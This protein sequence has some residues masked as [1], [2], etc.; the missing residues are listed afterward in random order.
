MRQFAKWIAFSRI[1]PIDSNARMDEALA[2]LILVVLTQLGA[3]N[4]D[5]AAYLPYHFRG[6]STESDEAAGGGAVG[7]IGL[8]PEIIKAFSKT[9]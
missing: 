4:V 8:D 6:E 7:G 9:D 5:I 3:K 1:S 2:R